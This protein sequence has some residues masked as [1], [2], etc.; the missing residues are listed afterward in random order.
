MNIKSSDK[1]V[2]FTVGAM[3]RNKGM[4]V[5]LSTF[6][7]L[8]KYKPNCCLLLLKG[9]DDLYSPVEYLKHLV[10]IYKL[11]ENSIKYIGGIFSSEDMNLLYNIADL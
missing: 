10:Q 1:I 4:D 9:L 11:P 6:H 8:I 7:K 3:T 2:F 5:L